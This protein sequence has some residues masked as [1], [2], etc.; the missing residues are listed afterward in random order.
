M[1]VLLLNLHKDS[2]PAVEQP[3]SPKSLPRVSVTAFANLH[4]WD[5]G[6]QFTLS[7]LGLIVRT[8]SME[9]EGKFILEG[10]STQLP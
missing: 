8:L 4:G 6:T 1:K 5:I 9:E 2:L 7:W 3:R 10:D